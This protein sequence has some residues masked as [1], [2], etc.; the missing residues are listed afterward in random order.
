MRYL[1]H[2][3]WPHRQSAAAPFGTRGHAIGLPLHPPEA[4]ERHCDPHPRSSGDGRYFV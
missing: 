1:I 4:Y 3:L 2:R